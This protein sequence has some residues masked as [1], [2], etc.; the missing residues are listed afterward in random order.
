MPTD[1]RTR[2][3]HEEHGPVLRGL[4]GFLFAATLVMLLW[5]AILPG[6]AHLDPLGWLQPAGLTL[7]ARLL[8]GPARPFDHPR[9][10]GPR[11]SACDLRTAG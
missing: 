1:H 4:L 5:N 6:L 9:H 8:L 10:R 2:P 7:L 3:G 11:L